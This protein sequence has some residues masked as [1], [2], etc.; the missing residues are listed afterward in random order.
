MAGPGKTLCKTENTGPSTAARLD[1]FGDEVPEDRLLCGVCA[2]YQAIEDLTRE[3]VAKV[4]SIHRPISAFE[5][6]AK[7][8]R[9]LA[10]DRWAALRY[11]TIRDRGARCECCG[12]TPAQGA[13]LA[14]D[15]IKPRSLYP[16]LALDPDNLQVL[17]R[18]CNRGKSNSDQTDW[19]GNLSESDDQDTPP[20]KL[21]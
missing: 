16:E 19:R 10:S 7:S 21:Q 4:N 3:R 20:E 14:V 12:A 9:F 5:Q 1:S 17:C 11:E 2:M 18:T 15:H 6:W 13:Q 8:G